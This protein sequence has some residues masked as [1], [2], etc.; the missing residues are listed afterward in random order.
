MPEKAKLII[1]IF[2]KLLFEKGQSD[3]RGRFLFCPPIEKLLPVRNDRLLL[4]P[5]IRVN[6]QAKVRKL[7]S[8]SRSFRNGCSTEKRRRK[9]PRRSDTTFSKN[10]FALFL[11]MACIELYIKLKKKVWGFVWY[12]KYSCQYKGKGCYR[13]TLIIY[14]LAHVL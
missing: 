8:S 14:G 5:M 1:I 6:L 12:A 2:V 9:R 10:H 13:G 11:V 3:P 4:L 7:R